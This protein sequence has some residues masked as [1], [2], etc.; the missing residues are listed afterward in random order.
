MMNYP[1]AVSPYILAGIGY[2]HFNP[3]ANLNDNYVDLQPLHTEGQ[4]FAEYPNVK[5]YKL[6]QINFPV[7]IGSKI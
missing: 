2:F 4:G 5:E 1:P 6:S 7:G 3:Q